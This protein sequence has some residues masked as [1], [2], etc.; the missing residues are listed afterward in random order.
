LIGDLLAGGLHVIWE[1]FFVPAGFMP[2]EA[3]RADLRF[4]AEI[5]E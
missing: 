1:R 5:T 2:L 3:G 4:S